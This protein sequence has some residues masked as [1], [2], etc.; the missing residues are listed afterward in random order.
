VAEPAYGSQPG[1]IDIV[2]LWWRPGLG[3]VQTVTYWS[4]T[5][6][7]DPL[8]VG[9]YA[10]YLTAFYETFVLFTRQ[11]IGT[12]VVGPACPI[13]CHADCTGDGVLSAPDYTCFM[14]RFAA[15]DSRANCDGSS[16]APALN[17]GDFVCFSNA[18]VAGCP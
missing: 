10:V 1:Q 5:V 18:F 14:T 16:T 7:V 15:G 12:V 2:V 11:P 3:C 8:P 4:R 6:P 13:P 17:V 9:E